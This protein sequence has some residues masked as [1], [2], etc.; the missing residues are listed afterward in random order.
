VCEEPL[1]PTSEL[2][3]CPGIVVSPHAS[4]FTDATETRTRTLFLNELGRHMHG[5]DQLNL[6]DLKRGY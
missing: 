4:S 1:P 2:W 6:V 3:S 5:L